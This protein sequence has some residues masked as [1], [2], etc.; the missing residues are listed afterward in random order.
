MTFVLHQFS[1]ESC[2]S[3]ASEFTARA[4][5]RMRVV[6]DVASKSVTVTCVGS[7][8]LPD[9]TTTSTLPCDCNLRQTL[10][11]TACTT[12]KSSLQ[13]QRREV[14]CGLTCSHT[15]RQCPRASMRSKMF[16][17]LSSDQC[18]RKYRVIGICA[19]CQVSGIFLI[20]ARCVV[21]SSFHVTYFRYFQLPVWPAC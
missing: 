14:C 10:E 5:Y 21:A 1:G 2:A 11:N 6:F 12:G 18:L 9:G 20:K 4:S 16:V 15:S 8:V 13:T 19:T 7:T 3:L 17:K